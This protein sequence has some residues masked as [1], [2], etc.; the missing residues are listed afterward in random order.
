[1]ISEFLAIFSDF[2]LSDILVLLTTGVVAG[3]LSGLFG[4]GGGIVLVPALSAIFMAQGYGDE[5]MHMA[6]GTSFAIVVPTGLT[7]ARAHA[8]KGALNKRALW[9]WTPGIL[10][11][12]GCGTAAASVMDGRS[13]TAVFAVAMMF[14]ALLM[15]VDVHALRRFIH[16]GD[17]P[18]QGAEAQADDPDVTPSRAVLALIGV[19]VGTL[20]SL[21][22]IGGATMT[23]PAMT[24]LGMNIRKAI[25]TASAVGLVISLPAVIGFIFIGRDTVGLEAAMNKPWFL[26]G[27][28]HIL[29][30]L[31]ILPCSVG[32]AKLGVR[33]AHA[34]PFKNLKRYFSV[35]LL[36]VAAKM[37]WG[38]YNS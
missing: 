30:A 36:V 7:S 34:L 2:S 18:A 8:K 11:G 29:A 14:L 27:Y 17:A 20:S 32:F 35:L 21:M 10:L 9:G 5:A 26:L 24:L 38:V 4:I 31:I 33:T 12:V 16:R 28:V 6:V 22:G 1:M 13:M 15:M 23:V 25:G 37:I 3:Y 19:G